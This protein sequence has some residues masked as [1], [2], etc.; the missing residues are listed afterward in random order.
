MADQYGNFTLFSKRNIARPKG[1]QYPVG[2]PTFTSGAVTSNAATNTTGGTQTVIG[3]V[4]VHTYDSSGTFKPMFDGFVNYIV[5]AGGGGG[6]GMMAGGGGGG[7]V[8]QGTI[9]LEN[10]TTYNVSVGGGGA[11]GPAANDGRNGS[12]GTNS[13]FA[14]IIASGGGYGG[15]GGNAPPEGAPNPGGLGGSGG[16]AG[17]YASTLSGGLVIKVFSSQ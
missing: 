6:G 13:M 14:T 11:G 3:G 1:Y 15:Q 17:G 16:G 12:N 4:A 9:F 5:V 8:R 2:L 10:N 7:G